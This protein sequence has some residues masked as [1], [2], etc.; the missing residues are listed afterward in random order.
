LD[1]GKLVWHFQPS[2]HDTH[3]WDA[4]QTPVLFDGEIK[5][6]PRKLLAQASRNGYFFVLDRTNGKNLVTSEYVK[7]NWAK[8]VDA[9]GQ[10]IPNPAKEP[11]LDGALVSPNQG[12]GANWP[13]PSYSP[14][15]GLFY[16]NATRAFSVYY[17]YDDDEKPEGWGGND[18]GGWGESMLQAIDYKTGKIRWS[19]KWATSGV[20]SGVLSTAGNL[21]FTG[22]PQ[23]NLVALDASNGKALWHAG[24]GQGPSNGPITY[25]L[26]GT[27]YLLVGAGDT[28]YAFAMW[29]P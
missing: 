5:G 2:P 23:G 21:V 28:L 6:A 17:I 20:R 9:K 1:T 10:P 11:Q 7:T 4:V 14:A 29:K 15:T 16:V 8:G 13:P 24:L 18:Q 3:D 25:E 19:H 27:Q 26:D 12:G 22:D